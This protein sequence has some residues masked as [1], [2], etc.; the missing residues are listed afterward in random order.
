MTA[1]EKNHVSSGI[2]ALIEKLRQEGVEKGRAEADQILSDAEKQAGL[3][4]RQAR[5]EADAM[6]I[7]AKR[8]VAR[9]QQA[10]ED[11]LKM[12]ARDLLLDVKENLAHSFNDQVERLIEQQ[13]DNQE[14]MQLMILELVGRA[15][16]E[17]GLEQTE[18][19]DVLLPESFIG[20]DELRRNADEYKTGRL[21]QFV[22]SLSVELLREGVSFNVHS[23]S[24]I[25]VRLVGKE[26]EVD[27]TDTAVARLLLRH[28][29]PRFRALLEGVIR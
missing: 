12:S 27:L 1:T 21:S 25:R 18:K 11:A 6:L 28:L 9:K 15:S 10:G 29:Q 24:G 13:M 4:L 19:I 23:G 7:K 20:L 22:Q 3:L 16:K 14:F 5:E 17:A 2:E 8:E 26:V